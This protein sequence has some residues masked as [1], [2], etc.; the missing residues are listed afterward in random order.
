MPN[1]TRLCFLRELK[2]SIEEQHNHCRN[3]DKEWK[4]I[5]ENKRKMVIAGVAVGVGAGAGKPF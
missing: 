1:F 4:E 3:Q 5:I 2:K